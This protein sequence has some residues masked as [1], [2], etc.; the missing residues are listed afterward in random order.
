MWFRK[1]KLGQL[2]VRGSE[3]QVQA[4]ENF[5]RNCRHWDKFHLEMVSIV[6]AAP[7]FLRVLACTHLNLL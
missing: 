6:S 5:C 1:V 7:V 2:R 3:L 4:K